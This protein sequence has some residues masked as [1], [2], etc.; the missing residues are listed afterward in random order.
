VSDHLGYFPDVMATLAEVAGATPP[1]N[2]DG[3]SIVPTLLGARAAGRDQP[4]H[5]YLY[6][7]DSGS[8]AVRMKD[9]KAVKPE[10]SQE[11]ELYDLSRDIEE[12]KNLAV[13]HPDVLAKMISY[14]R[15]AHTPGRSG[16]VRDPSMGFKGQDKN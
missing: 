12:N 7:E 2:T 14:A 11:Y 8:S 13:Q 4:Q 9:W 16:R 6:W 1:K 15:A 5:E 10:G 3:I